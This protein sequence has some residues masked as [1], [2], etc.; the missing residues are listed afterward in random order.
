MI[1][2]KYEI[3]LNGGVISLA[4]SYEKAVEAV[5]TLVTVWAPHTKKEDYTIVEIK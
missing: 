5:E 4:E 1:N 2:W 3:R